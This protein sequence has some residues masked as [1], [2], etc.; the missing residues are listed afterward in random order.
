[1]FDAIFL[2]AFFLTWALLGGLV[3]LA[4]S[5]R[6]RAYGAIWAFPFAVLG[7]MAGGVV[8]PLLGLDDGTGVGVS[9]ITA[10]AGGA[11]LSWAAYAVWDLYE[12][13]ARFQS[14][15]LRAPQNASRDTQPPSERRSPSIDSAHPEN[16]STAS[17][18]PPE[19]PVDPES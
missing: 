16:D 9:M 13:G 6:R 14:L 18:P 2:T 19:P 8:V 11:L 7:G 5:I 4:W 15:S 1:M 10:P 12:L 3:W 17:R